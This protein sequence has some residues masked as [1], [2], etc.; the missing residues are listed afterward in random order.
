MYHQINATQM[1]RERHLALLEEAE[2]RRLTRRLR[3]ARGSTQGKGMGRLRR[4]A[5]LFAAMVLALVVSS[6]VALAVTKSCE[7]LVQ[8]FGTRKV[9][10]LNGSPGVDYIFGRGRGDTLNGFGGFDELHGQGGADKLF[11][12][13]EEDNLYGDSGNDA[14]SGG[15]GTDRYAFALGWGKDSITESTPSSNMVAFYVPKGSPVPFSDDLIIK[16]IPGDGPEVTNASGTSTLN[17]DG[18][19]INKVHAGGGD[20]QIT[21]SFSANFI[22]ARSGGADNI[23][24]SFGDDEVHVDDGS[25][26]DVVNCGVAFPGFSNNDVVYYDPGDDVTNCEVHNP[27]V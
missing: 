19:V 10:T 23:S 15:E 18:N 27:Q 14:L 13:S 24:A 1:F 16:L 12:G 8:C 26:D 7:E 21:G 4:T 22:D 11:G 25:G 17:W 20:D 6:G 5:L 9:D 3:V 2:N